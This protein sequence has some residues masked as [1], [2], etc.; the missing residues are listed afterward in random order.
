MSAYVL[1]AVVTADIRLGRDV[2]IADRTASIFDWHA[3]SLAVWVLNFPDEIGE[4]VGHRPLTSIV[5]F[6]QSSPD[7]C[8]DLLYSVRLF[9]RQHDAIPMHGVAPLVIIKVSLVQY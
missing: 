4:A 7:L 1:I 8:S 2:P 6:P 9:P 5:V 3:R